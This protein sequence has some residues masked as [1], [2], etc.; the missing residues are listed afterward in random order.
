M[1]TKVTLSDKL[2]NNIV[3]VNTDSTED[4]SQYY[5]NFDFVVIDN[6]ISQEDITYLQDSQIENKR[7]PMVGREV[8]I[9][10]LLEKPDILFRNAESARVLKDAYQKISDLAFKR[11]GLFNDNI[12]RK[13][14]EGTLEENVKDQISVYFKPFDK[15]RPMH[16]DRY[17]EEPLRFFLNLDKD[18]RIWRTSYNQIEALSELAKKRSFG[19]TSGL[20]LLTEEKDEKPKRDGLNGKLNDQVLYDRKNNKNITPYHELEI[21]S[22]TLWICNSKRLSHQLVKGNRLLTFSR[23]YPALSITQDYL[24]DT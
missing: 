8:P 10:E 21:A 5:L 11:Y 24:P 3:F 20:D 23:S 14:F 1:Q 15:P 19:T 13:Y 16:L 9:Q 7:N 6:F 12:V 17:K 18:P 22:G 2:R 4:L